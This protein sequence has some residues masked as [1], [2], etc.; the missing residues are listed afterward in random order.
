M[1][2]L[3]Q[4][5]FKSL[6]TFTVAARYLN[7]TH[8]A[9]ELHITPSAVSHQ[10][11]RLESDLGCR[12]FIKEGK[13]LS[14]TPEAKEYAISIE[15]AFTQMLT[16]SKEL[17]G[18]DKNII[19]IGISSAFETK[20]FTTKLGIWQSNLPELDLRVRMITQK[21]NMAQLNLDVVLAG[22]IED[23]RYRSEFIY[24]EK[25]YPVCSK[26]LYSTFEHT[27]LEKILLNA[28]LID[29]INVN[30]WN[31][32][33]HWKGMTIPANPKVIFLSH[34]LL[35]LEATL[36]GQGIAILDKTLI[37]NELESGDL[38]LL[39]SS[40]YCHPNY[41]YYF[42]YLKKRSHETNIQKLKEW[43]KTLF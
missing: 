18:Y 5:S 2:S 11:K 7:F 40:A 31:N 6:Y 14:L 39:D 25:Y 23:I 28:T 29:L 4:L 20:R 9:N 37:K 34:T 19:K 15:Q 43:I 30:C 27:S 42:S 16:A 3:Y 26:S 41:A 35:M 36:S 13:L 10:I 24:D 17:L 21:D 1:N 38:I 33:F 32:W 22:K 12:L 8:A